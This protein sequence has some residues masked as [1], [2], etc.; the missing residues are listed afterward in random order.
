MTCEANCPA[1]LPVECVDL[2]TGR[3]DDR[4]AAFLVATLRQ[5]PDAVLSASGSVVGYRST[6]AV[7]T[8]TDVTLETATQ[9]VTI[10]R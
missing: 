8:S 2:C 6:E 4:C 3:R 10:H 5:H 1:N 9:V 7:S